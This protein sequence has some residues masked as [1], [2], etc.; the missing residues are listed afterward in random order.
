MSPEQ[1]RGEPLDPRSDLFSVGVLLYEMVTGQRPFQA[2]SSAALAAA[3]LTHEPP[4]L[5]RFAPH[6]PAELDRIVTKLLKKDPA[7][8][9]QTAEDLLIDLRTLK[10]EQEFQRSSGERRAIGGE[11]RAHR[12]PSTAGR[13]SRRIARPSRPLA[14]RGRAA[15]IAAQSS[16]LRH[17]LARPRRRRVVRVA[18][19]QCAAGPSRGS[20][21]CLRSPRQ[22]ATAEAFDLAVAV[23][24]YVPN[25][26]TITGLIPAISDTISVTT[27]PPGASIYLKRFTAAAPRGRARQL[28]G[29]SPLRTS[30]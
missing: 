4:P 28:L 21:R 16:W 25:D 15:S 20:R 13:S 9:Y 7:S 5:A 19:C 8:R 14:C 3:I 23:Q 24:R 6:T 1:A 10:E 2:T 22:G 27:E 18:D 12:L 29:T 11:R 26:P 30:A 17:A